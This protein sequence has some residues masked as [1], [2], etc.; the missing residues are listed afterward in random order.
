MIKF[1]KLAMGKKNQIFKNSYIFFL[2]TL[3]LLIILSVGNLK[4]LLKSI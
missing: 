4:N 1:P 3:I 2:Y